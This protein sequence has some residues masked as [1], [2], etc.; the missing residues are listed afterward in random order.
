MA[1]K[2]K[3]AINNNIVIKITV[4]PSIKL[5]FESIF[6]IKNIMIHMDS[7]TEYIKK[8]IQLTLAQLV[9]LL[10]LCSYILLYTTI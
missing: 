8:I 2:T 6:I 4:V 10:Y 5:P 3:M 9:F 1:V 7:L